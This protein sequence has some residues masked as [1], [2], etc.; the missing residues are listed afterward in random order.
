VAFLN[1]RDRSLLLGMAVGAACVIFGR[2][3]LTPVKRLARPTAKA[4]L[5][6]GWTALEHGRETVT[7]LGEQLEDLA[8]EVAAER[9]DGA[10]GH[11]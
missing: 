11:K 9:A 1:E 10:A 7:R 3:L 6:S 8:A 5:R 2:R 4:A